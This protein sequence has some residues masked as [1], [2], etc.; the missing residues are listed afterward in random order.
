MNIIEQLAFE[1]KLL[2]TTSVLSVLGLIIL[3]NFQKKGF[4]NHKIINI[5]VLVF[6]IAFIFAA[7]FLLYTSYNTYVKSSI[8]LE[9]LG[10]VEII[11]FSNSTNNEEDVQTYINLKVN[12]E[13]LTGYVTFLNET[14][15]NYDPNNYSYANTLKFQLIK[16]M[17]EKIGTQSYWDEILNNVYHINPK[18]NNCKR[19]GYEIMYA[20]G[21]DEFPDE[22][23]GKT[24]DIEFI[25]QTAI[26][27]YWQSE[28]IE[29]D[30]SAES[31][32]TF[33]R[34]N[35]AFMYTF[36][37]NLNTINCVSKS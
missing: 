8:S 9:A 35:R 11:D 34:S 5:F 31:I 37:Q 20:F 27:E 4:L 1:Q 25:E 21:V 28:L 23:L 33:W 26:Y 2:I 7:S 30:R 10:T 36:F 12:S 24:T 22:N 19:A 17:G 6:S 29:A 18:T 15:E 14:A 3:H 32:K 13:R 16:Q